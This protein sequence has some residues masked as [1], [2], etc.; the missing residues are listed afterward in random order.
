MMVLNKN[1]K[2]TVTKVTRLGITKAMKTMPTTEML[3]GFIL[4]VKDILESTC[5]KHFSVLER[6]YKY[7][8]PYFLT[9]LD[10]IMDKIDKTVV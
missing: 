6:I 8:I 3:G 4:K 9:V 2:I 5:K 7:V 10:M 1:L